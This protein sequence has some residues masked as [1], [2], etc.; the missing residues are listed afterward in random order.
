MKHIYNAQVFLLFAILFFLGVTQE[1]LSQTATLRIVGQPNC[2]QNQYTATIQIRA[3]DATSFSIGTS[4]VYLTYNPVSFSFASYQPLNFAPNNL[5]IGGL[6]SSWDNHTFD[7][8]TPG[9]FNLTL[10]LVSNTFSCPI[11]TNSDW[12]SIGTVTFSILNPSADPQLVFNS[13]LTNFNS[14]PANDG[15]NPILKGV[16]SGISLPSLLSSVS[17][18]AGASAC[19]PATN[20]Y[21]LSGTATVNNTT[22]P[23]ILTLTAGASSQT[24]AV[25]SGVSTVAYSFSGLASVG[26]TQT[27]A[28][29]VP[30][31]ASASTTYA[32][33]TSCS[34]A[35]SLPCNVA[36][37]LTPGSCNSATNQFT[38]T[39]ILNLTNT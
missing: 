8:T 22:Q 34:V 14:A 12:I 25:G 7:S 17:L 10:T 13:L 36:V 3:A 33:P 23:G 11:V 16:F 2:I 31:C 19:N 20:T 32:V 38:L 5:C 39:G 30:G 28:V 1:A 6:A 27:V 15:T 26:G 35:P 21:V 24:V 4:S 29:T 9:I 37:T 18:T